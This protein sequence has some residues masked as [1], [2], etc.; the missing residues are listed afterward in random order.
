MKE[1]IDGN[2]AEAAALLKEAVICWEDAESETGV[3][4][5]AQMS[6]NFVEGAKIRQLFAHAHL[7]DALRRLHVEDA[8]HAMHDFGDEDALDA[9]QNELDEAID[10]LW[11]L[12]HT[13]YGDDTDAKHTC[14]A[15]LE[16]INEVQE[17]FKD[18]VLTDR[19]T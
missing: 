15:V 1:T 6:A 19:D 18:I 11:E 7:R 13:P 3:G 8:F 10:A 9:A 12:D 4:T 14:Q 16:T 2:L 17:M 5:S